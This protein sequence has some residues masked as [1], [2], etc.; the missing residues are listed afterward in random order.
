MMSDTKDDTRASLLIQ[1]LIMYFVLRGHFEADPYHA[2]GNH[3]LDHGNAGYID[4]SWNCRALRKSCYFL[5]E[6]SLYR[7]VCCATHDPVSILGP[8]RSWATG[9]Y[10][11]VFPKFVDAPRHTLFPCPPETYNFIKYPKTAWFF[12]S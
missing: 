1:E 9:S 6:K 10:S 7:A 3:S 12:S 11:T 4:Q 5:L 2:L 8:Y